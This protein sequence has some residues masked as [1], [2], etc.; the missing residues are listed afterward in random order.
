MSRESCH[1]SR[2]KK[3]QKRLEND[4]VLITIHIVGHTVCACLDVLQLALDVASG[5][6]SGDVYRSSP[7]VGI[8]TGRDSMDGI[9]EA[10]KTLAPED[11]ARCYEYYVVGGSHVSIAARL[12]LPSR[13]LYDWLQRLHEAIQNRLCDGGKR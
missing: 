5:A 6:R 4:S 13:T 12:S 7:P 2:L 11:R 8:F 9:T 1:D 3:V 10:V